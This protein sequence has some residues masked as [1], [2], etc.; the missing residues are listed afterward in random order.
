MKKG[1]VLGHKGHLKRVP[2]VSQAWEINDTTSPIYRLAGHSAFE[3]TTCVRTH[4]LFVVERRA[5]VRS[6]I[7]A[8]AARAESG[9]RSNAE[10]LRSNADNC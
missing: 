1:E 2:R 10:H 5:C 7:T 8:M 9:V 3:R 4:Q 6:Q